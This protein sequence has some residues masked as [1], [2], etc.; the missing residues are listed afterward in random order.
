MDTSNTSSVTSIGR[1]KGVIK[2]LPLVEK[3]QK[4]RYRRTF[5]G[6]C[7]GAFLGVYETFEEARRAAPKTKHVGFDHQDYPSHHLDRMHRIESHDYPAILWLRSALR[8]GTRVFDFGGNV[9]VSYYAYGRFIEYPADLSWVVCEMAGMV[10]AGREIAAKQGKESLL[11]TEDASAAN[12]ADVYFAAGVLQYIEG[13]PL[14]EMLARLTEK[15]RH[16]ILNKLPL[17]DGEQFVTLQNSGAIVTPLY[18]FNRGDF[19]KSME[20]LSYRLIDSWDVPGYSCFVPF[21][22]GKHVPVYSGLY[23]RLDG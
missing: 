17:Y 9:G 5:A 22:P 15:P 20:R 1:I 11:F 19:V 3:A 7:Y 14:A 10:A 16:V 4:L 8:P 6:D 13:P 12:G 2:R 21:H 23:F 18:A